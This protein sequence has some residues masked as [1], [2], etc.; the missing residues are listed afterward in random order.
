M[1][2]L[3]HSAQRYHDHEMARQFLGFNQALSFVSR[4]KTL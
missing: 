3:P 4:L 2:H 1:L